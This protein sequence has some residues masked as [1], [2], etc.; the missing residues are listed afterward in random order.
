MRCGARRCPVNCAR[1]EGEGKEEGIHNSCRESL[2]SC[3]C[4]GSDTK[5][6]LPGVSF[7]RILRHLWP[8]PP[9]LLGG[10]GGHQLRAHTFALVNTREVSK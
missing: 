1:W 10:L 2:M 4:E 3:C 9:F 6:H 7:S 5:H 8:G